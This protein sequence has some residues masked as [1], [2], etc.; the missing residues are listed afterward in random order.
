MS[1]A[2]TSEPKAGASAPATDHNGRTVPG[3]DA[4]H[5]SVG[6]V[7]LQSPFPEYAVPRVFV[8]ISEFRHRVADDFA[9]NTLEGF[10]EQWERDAG[11]KTWAVIR[12]G[13]IGGVIT[14]RALSPLVS[15]AQCVFAKRFWGHETTLVALRLAF[16][17]VFTGSIG[18]VFT[19]TTKK[20]SLVL[21]RDNHAI[22]GLIKKLGGTVEGT[23]VDH[24]LRGGRP[25]DLVVIG[26]QKE[27]FYGRV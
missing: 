25:V 15:E 5:P 3:V 16:A 24:T 1:V 21:F 19:G 14:A 11:R 2:D 9:P 27:G 23:L 12:D 8:W 20:I 26:I 4:D 10:V 13:E 7:T 6:V 22:I 18:E 17:E